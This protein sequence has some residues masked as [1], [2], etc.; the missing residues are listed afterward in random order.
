MKG[1][2][3]TYLPR[4]EWKLQ[5]GIEKELIYG[6]RGWKEFLK[7]L[8]RNLSNFWWHG[9]TLAETV[10]VA[11]EHTLIEDAKWFCWIVFFFLN[12][13]EGTCLI[14]YKNMDKA[15]YLCF[16]FLTIL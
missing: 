2:L 6:L 16:V 13:T 11:V 7:K 3:K 10:N 1:Y 9:K 14:D 12:L 4:E 15:Q 5:P 8:A